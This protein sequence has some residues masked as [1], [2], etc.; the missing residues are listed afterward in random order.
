MVELLTNYGEIDMIGLDM[1]LGP[2]V[3]PQL[4]ATLKE[5]RQLRPNIMFRARGIGNYGDYFTPE[6]YVPGDKQNT[7]MPWFVIYP[8]ARSFSYDPVA[9][10][11]KGA[12]WIIHT[13][14]ETVAKGGN[15][16]IGIGPDGSGRFHPTAV[17]QMKEAGVWLNENGE[18]IYGTR[19]RAGDH[20][21]DGENVRFTRSKAQD[22]VYAICLDWPDGRELVLHGVRTEPGSEIVLLGHAGK[23]Q[24]HTKGSDTVIDVGAITQRPDSFAHVFKLRGQ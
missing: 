17:A 23:I 24:W 3:W 22:I 5:L 19:S 2:R 6:N 1:W 12:K 11:Y 4:K 15:L 14:V 10:N 16:E 13:L 20:W 18:A 21:H 9:E 8:L 7:G